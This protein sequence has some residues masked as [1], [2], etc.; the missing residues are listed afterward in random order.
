MFHLPPQICIYR[1]ALFLRRAELRMLAFALVGLGSLAER[2]AGDKAGLG[3]VQ[4]RK[5]GGDD[6]CVPDHQQCGSANSYSG[7]TTC[8]SNAMEC[9]AADGTDGTYRSCMAAVPSPPPSRPSPPPSTHSGPAHSGC[10]VSVDTM[11]VARSLVL[12]RKLTLESASS[13]FGSL[14]DSKE[15]STSWE[16]FM[17]NLP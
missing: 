9:K 2:A 15:F 5:L 17:N 4:H 1:A 14:L 3:S 10:S 13:T 16:G 7:S 11:A 8:C 12:Q 6:A